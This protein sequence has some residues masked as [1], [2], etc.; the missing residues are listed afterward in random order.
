MIVKAGDRVA[1]G[2]PLGKLGNSDETTGP[3]L[4]YPLMDGPKILV[5]DGLPA[6][7]ENTCKPI[8]KPGVYCTWPTGWPA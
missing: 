5:S 2:A 1:Q 3:R 7:F 4:H 8:P 6:L